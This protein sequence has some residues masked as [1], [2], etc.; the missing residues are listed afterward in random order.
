M[1]RLVLTL[2]VL[3]AGIV[4]ISGRDMTPIE[5]SDKM[6]VAN[7][8]KEPLKQWELTGAYYQRVTLPDGSRQRLKSYK[9]LTKEQWLELAKTAYQ[10]KLESEKE[11]E[12][13]SHC[14]N[15]L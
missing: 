4:C 3:C 13:C 14:G 11:P 6:T 9:E 7:T 2:V 1:K 5:T 12:I 15:P 10:S 8:I